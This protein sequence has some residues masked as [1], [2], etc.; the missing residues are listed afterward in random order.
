MQYRAKT[1]G[2]V[3][4]TFAHRRYF[5]AIGLAGLLLLVLLAVVLVSYRAE[6][7][8][9]TAE[10]N[11]HPMPPL[12]LNLL[13]GGAWKLAD[14]RGQVVAINYWA[15]WC[16]PCWQETPTLIKINREFA[17]RGFAIVGISV[18]ERNSNKV[19]QGV[20]NFVNLLKVPY[21]I[22]LMA[23]MSQ[24]SYGMEGL[25]TTILIDREGRIAR[26][27]IGAIREAVFR[28][29]ISTLLKEPTPAQQ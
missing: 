28:D 27:Y 11:R 21:P 13:N 20:S 6:G 29:D 23:P 2:D 3:L 14:H 22:A 10:K 16:G 8:S 7:G 17:P 18:D 9:V 15:S 26:T 24:V 5:A 25:P 1:T 12:Q 19:P 4:S